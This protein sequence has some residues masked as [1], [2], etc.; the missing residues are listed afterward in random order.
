MVEQQEA[1]VAGTHVRVAIIGAGFAGLGAALRLL[2]TGER[3]F[4]VL[5]RADEVGG[6]WRDNVYPGVA[7]DIPSHLYSFSFAPK[8]NWQRHYAQGAEIQEYLRDCAATPELS[9]YLRLSTTLHEAR[10]NAA[11]ARWELTTNRGRFTASVLVL[12]TG[13]FGT[14]NIPRIPGL[15]NFTGPVCHSARWDDTI[16]PGMR[17]AVVGSGASAIQLVPALAAAGSEV[18]NVQRSA[19][20]IIPKGDYPYT[21]QVQQQFLRD[22]AAR[23][24]YRSTIFAEADAG[25]PARI[26]G[27]ASQAQL[28]DRATK[29]LHSHILDPQLR[30]LLTPDYEIG[31]KR[32]LLS[33]DF[34]PAIASGKVALQRGT[35]TE[36][37]GQRL[38]LSD[39]TEQRVDAIVFA[40]GFEASQPA[41]ATKVYGRDNL[42]LAAHWRNGMVSY[43]S[44]AVAGF[45]NMF[46][47]GGPNSALGHNSAIAMMETQVEHLLSA[48]DYLALGWKS[49]EA[50]AAAEEE[51][52]AMLDERAAKTVWL[53]AG[54]VSWYRH[55]RTGRL[56]LLWPGT[57]AQYAAEYGRFHPAAFHLEADEA[58][59]QPTMPNTASAAVS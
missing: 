9:K 51:Y 20:W 21:A 52:T 13:R 16:R 37:Q 2:D 27:N 46:I 38:L 3:S 36:I 10:W 59:S 41:I 39:G 56:T 32:V 34:Y 44:T 29:H 1:D 12:G 19:A 49:C 28:Q 40:T 35:I 14:P 15:A 48:L 11:A 7:C 5:E 26:L 8:A 4:M 58:T 50:T 53:S 55:N 33:D 47:I 43:A 17:V 24:Q 31:C 6:T 25:F 22:D 42:Q 30:E 57:A 23:G 54:C 45:P 18:V